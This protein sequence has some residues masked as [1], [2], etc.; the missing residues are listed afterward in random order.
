MQVPATECGS[1]V[2]APVGAVLALPPA[3]GDSAHVM[4]SN[5]SVLGPLDTQPQGPVAEL[6]AWRGGRATVTLTNPLETG[7]HC[8][9]P[10]RIQVTVTG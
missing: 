10:W 2:M 4:S 3:T 7:S 5:P 1:M 8:A 9:T 6:R